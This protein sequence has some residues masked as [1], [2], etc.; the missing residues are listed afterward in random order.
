MTV[1]YKLGLSSTYNPAYHSQMPMDHHTV[2]Q[3]RHFQAYINALSLFIQRYC[4]RH[5][6][7]YYVSHGAAFFCLHQ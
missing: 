1:P 3:L 5:T 4:P 6:S 2:D 7:R